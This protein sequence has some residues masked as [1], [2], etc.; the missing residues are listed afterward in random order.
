MD[1]TAEEVVKAANELEAA[2]SPPTKNEGTNDLVEAFEDALQACQEGDETGWAS[3]AER[4]AARE[5]VKKTR[6]ALI[7]A[8]RQSL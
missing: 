5:K 2:L 4:D 8:L 1:K 3:N 7:L 6:L